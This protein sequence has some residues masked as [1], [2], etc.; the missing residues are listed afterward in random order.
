MR[1]PLLR[2]SAPKSAG[3]GL[4]LGQHSK[5]L[6]AGRSGAWGRGE[7]GGSD[8]CLAVLMVAYVRHATG[9]VKTT[10]A[11]ETTTTPPTPKPGRPDTVRLGV[12]ASRLTRWV[13]TTLIA[14][15]YLAVF[16]GSCIGPLATSRHLEEAAEA[17][18]EAA[19]GSSSKS[20]ER[21]RSGERRQ[22]RKHCGIPS[23]SA[24]TGWWWPIGQPATEKWPSPGAESA[25]PKTEESWLLWPHIWRRGVSA[26]LFAIYDTR[27]DIREPA[28]YYRCG[29]CPMRT[30]LC[31]LRHAH[32]QVR[33]KRRKICGKAPACCGGLLGSRSGSGRRS[34]RR[35]GL[36]LTGGGQESR[37]QP[38]AAVAGERAA[39]LDTL[40]VRARLV[41]VR[42]PVAIQVTRLVAVLAGDLD[43]DNAHHRFLSVGIRYRHHL[44]GSRTSRHLRRLPFRRPPARSRACAPASNPLSH[45]PPPV[46]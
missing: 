27:A 45:Q 4:E 5:R 6:G 14:A 21:L 16:S 13:G 20:Y 9:T 17:S 26:Y 18:P 10:V 29:L 39:Q 37:A 36:R 2:L 44:R 8:C 32:R 38:A 46:S 1:V 15:L 22:I 42:M 34:V 43:S 12:A 28:T 31:V 3:C 41:A 19:G 40:I 30:P 24:P 33:P 25:T 35:F 11:P 23:A 7:D